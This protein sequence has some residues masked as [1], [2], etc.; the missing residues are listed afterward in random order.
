MRWT[1]AAS[2]YAPSARESHGFTS[3]GG[4][5][6]VHGGYKG[7]GDVLRAVFTAFSIARTFTLARL[8]L[9]TRG[10]AYA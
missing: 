5:L 1:A 6:Y 3:A 4:L 8:L 7:S 10:E 2:T 9:H